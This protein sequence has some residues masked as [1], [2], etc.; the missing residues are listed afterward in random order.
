ML[1][2][3]R[4]LLCSVVLF[5]LKFRAIFS[6]PYVV[7]NLFELCLF[8]FELAVEFR[9]LFD[10][11]T[12]D[13]LHHDAVIEK[14]LLEVL[15]GKVEVLAAL[16]AD[17]D[18]IFASWLLVDYFIAA[19]HFALLQNGEN[20][21]L[22]LVSSEFIHY[23]KLCVAHVLHRAI[24]VERVRMATLFRVRG[25]ELNYLLLVDAPRLFYLLHLT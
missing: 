20:D 7:I 13:G 5:R 8:G 1:M 15:H 18:R 17:L 21:L 11:P 10:P 6:C 4:Q 12:E 19:K 22:S 9:A 24:S 25:F 23:T 14:F 2:L 3:M 16:R